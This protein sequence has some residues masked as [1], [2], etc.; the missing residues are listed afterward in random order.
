MPT[1]LTPIVFHYNQAVHLH[2]TKRRCAAHTSAVVQALLV[3]RLPLLHLVT[4][5][6]GIVL[7]QDNVF[8]AILS[9]EED[10]HRRYI[11]IADP[12]AK[13]SM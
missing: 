8:A 12:R 10:R 11:K 2:K 4:A 1:A 13:L 5:T 7:V 3:A 9:R 6:T